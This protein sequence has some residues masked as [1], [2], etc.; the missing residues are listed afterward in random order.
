MDP[1]LSDLEVIVL[2][3]IIIPKSILNY[4]ETIN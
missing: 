4:T 2:I 3:E 1:N